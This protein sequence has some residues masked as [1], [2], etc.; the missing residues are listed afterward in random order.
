M[1]LSSFHSSSFLT[2]Q[3]VGACVLQA[4][5][6]AVSISSVAVYA[7]SAELTGDEMERMV[8]CCCSIPL[9]DEM[10][11]GHFDE[12]TE[13]H[14]FASS[15][16]NHCQWS[17]VSGPSLVLPSVAGAT[18]SVSGPCLVLLRSAAGPSCVSA[19]LPLQLLAHDLHTQSAKLPSQR[20]CEQLQSSAHKP[21][22]QRR[23]DM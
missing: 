17:S 21:Y 19:P 7:W 18:L 6:V 9:A 4:C 1:A 12:V 3:V 8:P 23:E 5:H 14:A 20:R 16:A 11:R 13:R 2:P 22:I 10:E 15:L